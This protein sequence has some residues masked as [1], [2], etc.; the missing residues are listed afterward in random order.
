VAATIILAPRLPNRLVATA[1]RDF[2]MGEKADRL[3]TTSARCEEWTT[4]P[5]PAASCYPMIS[6]EV[7][8]LSMFIFH[9]FDRFQDLARRSCPANSIPCSFSFALDH[10]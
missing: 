5:E 9:A 6:R 2:S 7:H 10:R 4:E 8:S 1:Y 3:G